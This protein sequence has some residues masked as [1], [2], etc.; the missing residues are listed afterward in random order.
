M[1]ISDNL[2]SYYKFDESSGNASDSVGSNT[3]TNTGLTYSAG[4]INNGITSIGGS[5][6]N[7]VFGTITALAVGAQA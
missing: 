7:S 3:G 4:I 5:G 1:A 6:Q 2:I